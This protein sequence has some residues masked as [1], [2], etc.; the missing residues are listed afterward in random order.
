MEINKRGERAVKNIALVM[1]A[2]LLVACAIAPV[3]VQDKPTAPNQCFEGPFSIYRLNTEKWI[4]L[5]ANPPLYFLR[6]PVPGAL[7]V[8]IAVMIIPPGKVM[9][10]GYVD[11]QKF[12]SF[13]YSP[14]KDCYVEDIVPPDV[15]EQAKKLLLKLAKES[16]CKT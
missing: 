8:V 7:P 3:I 1:L 11:G 2:T 6:N 5:V 14:E 13:I 12:R 10:Y 16:H 4:P 9:G 15:A